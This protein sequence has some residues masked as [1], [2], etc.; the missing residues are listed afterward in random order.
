LLLTG[1]FC[2]GCDPYSQTRI[3]NDTAEPVEVELTLDRTQWQHG[4]EPEEYQQWLSERTDEWI[5]GELHEYLV[6]EG[7]ELVD[8]DAARFA[9]KYK[10]E[11]SALLIMH[12]GMGTGPYHHLSEL[13]VIKG[14]QTRTFSGTDEIRELFE[15]VEG[16]VWE[17]RISDAL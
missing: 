15:R 7:V 10:L 12:E 8:V 6:F 5:E 14:D 9:G 16:N 4:F 11:P 3:K 1:A 13:I 2:V 17:F